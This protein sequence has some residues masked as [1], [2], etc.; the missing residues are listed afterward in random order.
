MLEFPYM[1][2]PGGTTRPMIAVAIEGPAG[3][4][5]ADG[6]LD[7][8]S[9]RT[10]FPHREA[11]SIGVGLPIAPDGAFQTAGG[12]SIAYRLA[13]V[14][15]ELRSSTGTTVRWRTSVAFAEDPL[16]I[17]HLGYR[18]FLEHFHCTFLGPEKTVRLDP[19]P[20]LP[21]A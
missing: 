7:T 13:E 18:G 4:R 17:I 12:I 6:L 11:Q 16:S 5:L 3:R 15:L 9:D 1:D 20:V 10:I 14:V 19:S 2:L 8:G 21:T